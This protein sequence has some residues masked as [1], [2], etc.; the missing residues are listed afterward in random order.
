MYRLQPLGK[1]LSLLTELRRSFGYATQTRR[2]NERALETVSVTIPLEASVAS[3]GIGSREES[4]KY[5]PLTSDQ[6]LVII[7]AD[8]ISLPTS[9]F[10]MGGLLFG[11]SCG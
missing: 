4:R 11:K 7:K 5:A 8:Q 9:P 6:S 3:D 10:W 2:T 1:R